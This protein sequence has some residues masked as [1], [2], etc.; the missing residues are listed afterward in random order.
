[1]SS[2]AKEDWSFD[3]QKKKIENI[4]KPLKDCK[5]TDCSRS[6]EEQAFGTIWGPAITEINGFNWRCDDGSAP[7]ILLAN[8]DTEKI[9]P[10]LQKMKKCAKEI[11]LLREY[12]FSQCTKKFKKVGLYCN[13]FTNK[14]SVDNGRISNIRKLKRFD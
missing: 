6:L 10:H 5:S 8:G 3:A 1:M 11:N 9:K 13:K 14:D 2:E 12:T 7:A 4:F